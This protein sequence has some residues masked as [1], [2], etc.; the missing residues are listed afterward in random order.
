MK[1]MMK[2][3][4]TFAL[5]VVMLFTMAACG[6]EPATKEVDVPALVQALL[7]KVQFASPMTD[8]GDSAF[9]Y[10]AN[11]PENTQVKLYTGS[12]YYADVVAML[13]VEK[14]S[15][16]DEAK[17]AVQNYVAQTRN[18]F[19]Q[20]IP[21][22][23]DKIDKAVI[24][25]S[26][27]YLVLCITDDYADAKKLLDSG[28]P[29]YQLSGAPNN[30]TGAPTTGT[31]T[32][33]AVT[34]PTTGAVTKPTTGTV[35][36]VTTLP[37]PTV[38]GIDYDQNGFPIL[39]SK[40]G[41]WINYSSGIIV[42][43]AGFEVCGFDDNTA[44]TYANLLNKV[45]DA[46]VGQ[47]KVYSLAI[48]T[49]Y[50]IMLPNDIQAKMNY[51]SPVTM[52]EKLDGYLNSNV[53]TVYCADNL[54]RHR[55]EYIYFRT[56][57]HWNGK[58]AYYAY[59]AFCETKG[60]Q[61]YTMAQREEVV[62]EGFIGS[63]YEFSNGHTALSQPDTIYAYKPYCTSAT[64][65][66]YDRN[67]KANN[68]PIIS[69]ASNYNLFAGSDQPLAVFTN[70]EVTD[71]SVC[72][73]VKESFGN[74][75]LPYLVDHYST[76]YEI[77]YRYW[78]GDLVSYAKQVGADELIFANNLGMISTSIMVAKLANIIH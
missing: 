2:R 15:D 51:I 39:L 1:K 23:L 71:G 26:G 59:E 10:F 74:A 45:A 29:N 8:A 58:G 46:L 25:E 55:N 35:P 22:E 16:L 49:G 53:T 40:S 65:V 28:D 33:G 50:T 4:V 24:W 11:L 70:P 12:G 64:M 68:W 30:T 60:I 73:V 27:K 6:V 57:H 67:G 48:P 47:T 7:N 63:L 72:I 44:S 17:A 36:P 20:Y 5:L 69:S 62:R 54:L 43:N 77:D 21:E 14:E 37:T 41:T 38:P 9:L 31:P 66:Y 76:I 13:T 3:I 52:T 19:G 78:T 34:K 32:T 61:P 42:D 75:L 56:D 18:Q